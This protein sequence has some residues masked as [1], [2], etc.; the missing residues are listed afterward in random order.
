MSTKW[1]SLLVSTI[2]LLLGRVHSA[3]SALF[4][5]AH[6]PLEQRSS[7]PQSC[8]RHTFARRGRTCWVFTCSTNNKRLT[9]FLSLDNFKDSRRDLSAQSASSA[10]AA[11]ESCGRVVRLAAKAY[12]PE[13]SHPSHRHYS[14]RKEQRR[15]IQVTKQGAFGDYNHYRQT[16]LQGTLDRAIS[17]VTT[18]C[19]VMLHSY[20]YPA[21][22]GDLGE[23]VLVDQV[24]FSFLEPG[25]VYRF[26]SNAVNSDD[27]TMSLR[28][29]ASSS[30]VDVRITEAMTPC[31][32]LCKLS[33]INDPDTPLLD[34]VSKCKEMLRLLDQAP[35]LRGW[36]ATVLSEGTIH[37][38]ATM[39][40]ID[41]PQ[42][43][44]KLS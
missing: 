42:N 22:P 19:L 17:I 6:I 43:D 9:N 23:N 27:A 41:E 13:Q 36:Y 26:E 18:D 7:L 11:S 34:R 44:D 8:R 35:G 40:R 39:K 14:T 31:A 25:G 12:H 20:G 29:L 21:V 30:T 10:S 4:G 2:L 37:D 5:A 24:Q 28:F 16:A 38:T 32:N 33:Y 15:A 3:R 1:S